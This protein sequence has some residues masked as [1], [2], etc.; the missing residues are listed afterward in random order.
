MFNRT[1]EQ[2][3]LIELYLPDY[4]DGENRASQA[5]T[6][7]CR[8]TYKWFND[9][10]VFDNNYYMSGWANDISGS[11]NRLYEY[12]PETQ[13]ILNKIRTVS[14]DREYEDLLEELTNVVLKRDR[15][16]ELEGLAKEG[17]AYDESGPF[18]FNE[19]YDDDEEEDYED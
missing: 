1:A 7:L 4:D 11:A 10:D 14:S 12:M 15:L 13:D 18:S 16:K 2:E 3:E 9:G 6:A 5:V 17:D 8:L 19:N